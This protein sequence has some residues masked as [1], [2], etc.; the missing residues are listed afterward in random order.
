MLSFFFNAGFRNFVRAIQRGGALLHA[1]PATSNK[2][3]QSDH[4]PKQ[5]PRPKQPDG[6]SNQAAGDNP[7]SSPKAQVG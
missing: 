3:K 1:V 6:S 4:R 7:S 5:Q 2:R